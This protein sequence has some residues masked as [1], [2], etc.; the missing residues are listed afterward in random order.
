M[1]GFTSR[2]AIVLLLLFTGLPLLAQSTHPLMPG[3][4][5][6]EILLNDWPRTL[7]DKQIT[8]FSPLTLGM[9]KPP[10]IWATV[11]TGGELQSVTAILVQGK[12]MLLVSDGHLRLITLNGQVQWTHEQSAGL[13]YCGNIRSN[14]RDY[15]LMTRGPSLMLIDAATGRLDW[16]FAFD[17]ANVQLNIQ[18]ADIMPDQPGLEAVVFQGHGV[19]ACLFQFPPKGQPII[20]WRINAVDPAKNWTG[21]ADHG[22]YIKLDMSVPDKPMVWNVRHHR[23]LGFD[24]LTGARVSTAEYQI[25][26]SIRRNYGPGNFGTG[27]NGEQLMIVFG[28]NIEEHVHAFGLNRNGPSRLLWQHYYG[29]AE[30]QPGVTVRMVDIDDVDGDGATE[31]VYNVRDPKADYRSFVRVCDAMTGT[32]EVQMDDTWALAAFKGVGDEAAN[33][34][35]VLPASKGAIPEAGD[36]TVYKF[37]GSGEIIAIGTVNNARI[38]GSYLLPG[39][40]GND[41]VLRQT[42]RSAS[43]A[44]L[45]YSLRSGWWTE[46]GRT[47]AP[48]LFHKPIAHVLT[49]GTEQFRV[50]SPQGTLQSITWAGHLLSEI[51]LTGGRP[52]AISAADLNSDGRAELIT[53]TQNRQLTVHS[54]DLNGNATEIADYPYLAAICTHSPLLYDP[55]GTGNWILIAPAATSGNHLTIRA[56]RGDGSL[57][58]NTPLPYTTENNTEVIAVNAARALSGGKSV[59]VAHVTDGPRTVQSSIGINAHTGQIL[60]IKDGIYKRRAYRPEGIVS[61]ADADNDGLDELA[62]NMLS[63]M[64]FF[65]GNDGS[66]A[67]IRHAGETLGGLS[68]YNSFIPLYKNDTDIAPHWL[69]PS[70][71]GMFGMI[72]PDFTSIWTEDVAYDV[73]GHVGIVDIDGDGV[74]EAGYAIRNSSIFKCRNVWTGQIKWQLELTTPLNSPVLSAD[75]DGDGKGEFLAGRYVIGTNPA[76]QGEVRFELPVPLTIPEP[77]SYGYTKASATLIADFDG[78]GKGE[79]ACTTNGRVHILKAVTTK[80]MHP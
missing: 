78:D 7:H 22:V 49:A 57:L 19:E 71:Y 36:V 54:F 55:D 25:G 72:G 42:D 1:H 29:Y 52:P 4:R 37:T 53:A 51:P 18:V 3:L 20:L 77:A 45:R 23:L 80:N 40:V 43:A 38:W 64:A 62:N 27:P 41:I 70:G 14:G 34:M 26:G 48:A 79:I 16:Q 67:L 5:C 60:W 47:T 50:V 9:T 73:P 65:N 39:R 61:V 28:E 31:V 68:L 2:T 59:L 30:T 74:L 13:V 56:Y 44:L 17:D 75:V 32:I 10:E 12:T 66:F 69:V 35:L 58:W 24:A 46:L 6:D 21:M 11:D 33:G 63:F 76:G 8:G 15:L